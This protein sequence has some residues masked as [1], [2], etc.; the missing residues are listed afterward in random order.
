MPADDRRLPIKVVLPQE[1]DLR[2]VPGGG[3]PRKVFDD[4]ADRSV[5]EHLLRQVSELREHFHA[6]LEPR[7][8]IPA[9][10]RVV[11]KEQA[12]AKSHRPQHLFQKDTCPIIGGEMFG[13]LLVSVSGP[14]L[15]RL[16][17]DIDE[18]MAKDIAADISTVIRIEPYTA[19]DAAGSSGVDGLSRR[20]ATQHARELKLR[21]F[22]HKNAVADDRV[23]SAFFEL[24]ANLGLPEPESVPYTSGLR[25]YRVRGVTPETV[26]QLAGFV[27]AQSVGMFPKFR[28]FAQYIPQGTVSAE[29]FPAPDPNRLYPLV[30][31]IDS[32]TDPSNALLQAWVVD[33]DEEDVPRADQCNDHGSFVAGL[34]INGRQLNHGDTRFPSVQAKIIDVVALP[35]PDT[36]AEESDL[37][38]TIRRAVQKY[39]DVRTWNLSISRIEEVCRDDVFSD[40]AM[41]LDAIQRTHDVTFVSCAGNFVDPPLRGWPPEDLGE[42]DRV[43]PPAD[44]ALCVSVGSCAHLDHA[45]ARVRRE[46]PSPFSRR[47]PGAAFLPKP[48]LCHYGGNCSRT[49]DYHQMGV[50]SLDG[51]GHVAE[52]IGTS[53]STPLVAS[54]LANVRHGITEP[55][56]RNLAKALL[57]QSAAL[58]GG[59]IVADHLRYRGFGIPGE[60]DEILTCAP[61]QATLILE[62]EIPPNRRIFAREDFPIPACFRRPDGRVEGEFLMTLVYD[63]PLD[64]SAGAEYCQVNIDVSLGTFDRG[65]DGKPQ[66]VGKIPLE[67]EDYARL[68][69]RHLVEHGFK[70]SPVKVYRKRLQRTSGTRWRLK[71][72]AMYRAGI[73]EA[74]A[75]NAALVVTLFDPKRQKPVYNDVV[76]AMARSG[77][78]TQD[79][80]VDERIRA[81]TRG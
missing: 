4:A 41:E 74:A 30:G 33:R 75:Q 52:A 59:P 80:Q 27:G 69:E 24:A 56:S 11:L 45:S 55:T 10:A 47:G 19:D 43:L 58:R 37:L 26:P 77:W 23:R 78:A 44:S 17:T 36:P 73:T 50:V 76:T 51:S 15:E 70:W 8:R 40:F 18:R 67:P 62:P 71:L 34:I 7:S 48:E 16:A 1:Q 64:P 31:I 53:F 42:T 22:R 66:H 13:N 61:W 38:G 65:P 46:Q 35:K 79:L 5:R 49:L 9:V 3:S 57:V 68:Y 29:R 14:G 12:L 39:P 28:L 20:V 21:L 54:I 60:I 25:I 32:G 2:P 72:R 81:R 6:V 63:P